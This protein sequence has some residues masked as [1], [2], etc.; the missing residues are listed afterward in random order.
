MKP[1]AFPLALALLAAC[2]FADVASAADWPA[3]RYDAQRS[4]TSP[5]ALPEKLALHWSRDLL[6]PIPAW[7]DQE[8]MPFDL[9]A[10]PIVFG[11]T[12]YVNSSRH[13]CVRALDVKTGDERWTFFADGPIRFAPLAWEGKLYVVSDDGY[14]YCLEA[15]TGKLHWKFRGGPHNRRV[16]GNERMISMWP[17]RGAPVIADDTL[18]FA[19]SIWPFMGTFIHALDARTGAPVW[20]NDGDGCVYIK[21]PHMTDSFAGIAPQGPL[22]VQG[23][24]LILPGGRSVPAVLDRKTGKLL[25]YQL[26]EHGKRGGGSEVAALGKFFF[27]GGA[28]FE[29]SSQKY[30]GD[31]GK[32][33]ALADDFAAM[34]SGNSLRIVDPTPPKPNDP[35][36]KTEKDPKSGDKTVVEKVVDAVK[37]GPKWFSA[38]LAAATM[39][40]ALDLI[41]AG[42][43][44]YVGGDGFVA[45]FDFDP[46]RKSLTPAWKL[47]LEGHADNILA[48]EDRLIV[49]TREGKVFCFG[50]DRSDP[51]TTHAWKQISLPEVNDQWSEKANDILETGKQ[52]EGWALVLQGGTGRLAEE[53]LRRTRLRIVVRES[54]PA[55]IQSLRARWTAMDLYGTRVSILP[56]DG[57]ESL[58]PYFASLV[59]SEGGR[60]SSMASDKV[61]KAYDCLRP[62]GGLAAIPGDAS[63]MVRLGQAKMTNAQMEAKGDYVYV[64]RIG[65]PPGSGNWTH[66]HADAGNSRVSKDR[67]VKAPM[68]LLWF[69]GP[70]NDGILPRHGHGPQPHAIDGRIIIEGVDLIRCLDMYTGRQLWETPLPGVGSFYNNVAHQPGANASG[71]N[72]VSMPDGI[73]VAYRSGCTVLDPANGNPI[74]EFKVPKLPG[75][76]PNAPWGYIDVVGDLLIGGA[77]PIFDVKAL[78]PKDQGNGNDDEPAGSKSKS[79]DK[80]LKAIKGTTDNLSASRYLFALDRHTGKMVWTA[81]ANLGFRHN[82][83]CVGGGRVYAIDRLSG[84]QVSKLKAKKEE[85][86]HLPRLVALDLATGRELWSES[87]DIFG[88]WLSWSEKHDVLVEAGRVARDTLKDEPKGMRAYNAKDGTVLWHQ[89]TYLG[90]AMIHGDEILQGQGACDLLTGKQKMRADPITGQLTPWKWER[91]YGCNTPSASE[92]LMLFR[93]GAAG[94]FDLCNDG[95][96]GNFGGFRSSCTNNLLVAGGVL[97]VPE[98][99][100]TCTCSYQNQTSVALIHMPENEMWTSFGTKE[101]R[102]PVRRVG[103][104]FGGSGDRRAENGTLWLEYPS[105]GGISPLVQVSMNPKT[106]ELYRRHASFV[107]GPMAWVA[108]SGAKGLSEAT[109]TLGKKNKPASFTVRLVFAEPEN[110]EP[111]QR[112]FDVEI[113]GQKVLRG[114]DIVKEAGGPRRSVVKEFFGFVAEDS[115]TVRLIPASASS[116]PTILSGMEVIAEEK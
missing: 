107:D 82:G 55:K 44:I 78:P 98:Y 52:T 112:V 48:A 70:T 115:L 103:L 13:D 58:P 40:A 109:L 65:A 4:G 73:Y 97:V 10:E 74:H 36:P 87:N 6:A 62:H 8:K 85:P 24:K 101:L 16:L 14:L 39:P 19:A 31:C 18:Y 33:I 56:A 50:S 34:Y 114:F 26:A 32:Q 47:A 90:P 80:V 89:P 95:G 96:T 92:N 81:K 41:R 59:V 17:A 61:A 43:R 51:P 113:Q 9:A 54:D 53:L 12:L 27:N 5:K 3:W 11:Q 106:P 28:V 91:N 23:D 37:G 15:D 7:P 116:R 104:N 42:N 111:G 30:L 66:E 71:S 84:E 102:G 60:W 100:R 86:E 94:F 88:T 35:A 1:I 75:A 68:G 63:D 69:G 57:I 76:N 79:L 22:V 2:P 99:T 93:S 20:T 46:E 77:D 49:S 21:Q 29:T 38:E 108:S 72:F 25:K 110:L 45:A 64:R 67:L 83:I 105:T